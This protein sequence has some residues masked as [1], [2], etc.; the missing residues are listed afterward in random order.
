MISD[1]MI[2]KIKAN[3]KD[4][5][6]AAYGWNK[7][8]VDEL[9]EKGIEVVRCF[10]ANQKLLAEDPDFYSNREAMKQQSRDYYIVILV[11]LTDKPAY[12][13]QLMTEFG[14]TEIKDYVFVTIPETL[15]ADKPTEKYTDIFGNVITNLPKNVS[16]SING[17]GNKLKFD[18]GSD[19]SGKIKISLKGSDNEIEIGKGVKVTSGVTEINCT[20]SFNKIRIKEKCRFTNVN[21]ATRIQLYNNGLFYCGKNT[22][23]AGMEA[24]LISN[25]F[26]EIG[27][28]CNVL[29]YVIAQT[30]G[31]HSV[32]DLTTDRN[33]SSAVGR[34]RGITLGD[35]VWV[36]MRSFLKP[37]YVGN[38]SII[39]AQSVIK[40][41]FPNNCLIT[42]SPACVVRKNIAWT[43]ASEAEDMSLCLGYTDMTDYSKI[44]NI[45]TILDDS[46][47]IEKLEKKV[48]ALE[49]IIA[50]MRN[51]NRRRR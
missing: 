19:F 35:H 31:G 18:S 12:Q 40:G 13:R 17:W 43:S 33:I 16:V 6:I 47:R 29:S 38:G 15:T 27:E 22:V 25:T 11:T 46:M 36:G 30:G 42:G 44:R 4:R 1:V 7:K 50:E 28:N 8:L 32:F 41:K 49:K 5:F 26:L 14:Y 24:I 39:G 51:K 3:S 20:G 48:A 37:C 34:R 45:E 23:I 21:G 2:N 10:S 9:L